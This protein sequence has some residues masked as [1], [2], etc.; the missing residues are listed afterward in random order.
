MRRIANDMSARKT[1]LVHGDYSPKNI[2]QDGSD[3]VILD[4]DVAQIVRA[5]FWPFSNRCAIHR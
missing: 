3:M 2:L 5:D 4:Y 1:A